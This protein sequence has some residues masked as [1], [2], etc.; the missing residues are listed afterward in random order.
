MAIQIAVHM[1]C[2]EIVLI[3]QDF[4]FPGN[5]VYSAGVDH[6]T[7]DELQARLRNAT[8][9]V[10]NVNGGTNP[11]SLDMIHLKSDVEQ[12][13]AIFE[14]FPFYNAS[15]IGAIIKGTVPIKLEEWLQ[16]KKARTIPDGWLQEQMRQKLRPM[17]PKR[18]EKIKRRIQAMR[19]EL[20]DF[21]GSLK[22]LEEHITGEVNPNELWFVRFEALWS[23]VVDHELYRKVFFFFLAREHLAAERQWEDMRREADLEL[24]FQKLLKCVAPLVVELKRLV[25]FTSERLAD[26]SVKLEG[27]KSAATIVGNEN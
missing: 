2:S 5:S 18:V 27:K 4:S 9:T 11:T 22:E 3:G 23:R 1:G 20:L 21:E 24:K 16:Q 14:D 13:I 10:E 12:L 17:S 6:F 15:P 7:S 26:L 19:D 25:P 8:L